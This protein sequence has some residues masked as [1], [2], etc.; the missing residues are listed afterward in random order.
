MAAW[1]RARRFA[2]VEESQE[3]AGSTRHAVSV[4]MEADW[5]RLGGA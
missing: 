3:I 1:E 2:T 5:R 4:I